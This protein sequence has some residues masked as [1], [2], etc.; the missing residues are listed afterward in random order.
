MPSGYTVGNQLVIVVLLPTR[1]T[2]YLTRKTLRLIVNAAKYSRDI[3]S[4]IFDAL[5]NVLGRPEGK[6]GPLNP[7]PDQPTRRND[8]V[9]QLITFLEGKEYG[10]TVS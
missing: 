8:Q 10:P 4:G 6:R 7:K 1:I 3:M 9:S 2:L 5:F